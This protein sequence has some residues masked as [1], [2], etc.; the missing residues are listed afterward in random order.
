MAKYDDDMMEEEIK[1]LQKEALK[2]PSFEGRKSN[3]I[4]NLPSDTALE[5]NK[6]RQ[7]AEMISALTKF[8]RAML[9]GQLGPTIADEIKNRRKPELLRRFKKGGKVSSASTRADGIAQRGKTRGR[10]I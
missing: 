1:R 8:G 10:M 6:E 4:P 3:R 7:D 5:S 9:P 2:V